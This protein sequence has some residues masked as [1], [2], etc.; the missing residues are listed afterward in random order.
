MQPLH[1]R[2]FELTWKVVLES[3]RQDLALCLKYHQHRFPLAFVLRVVLA[4]PLKLAS[5]PL[6]CVRL[7]GDDYSV[8]VLS[9]SPVA[10]TPFLPA[11][12]ARYSSLSAAS[13]R[14]SSVLVEPLGTATPREIVT[15]RNSEG[16]RP[17]VQ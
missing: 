14:F 17:G 7:L 1:P 11:L 9:Q 10:D 16:S 12:L 4:D 3:T 2:A 6:L 15:G 8:P 13:T 5:S